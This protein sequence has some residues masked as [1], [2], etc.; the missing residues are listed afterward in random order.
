MKFSAL[1]PVFFLLLAV[2]DYC[3]AFAFLAAIPSILSAL[4]KRDV[5][6]QKYV[7]IKRR[8]LDLDDMLSKLFED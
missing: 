6:T 4:G 8:D 3:Q 5:K 7:D 2:I 1:L